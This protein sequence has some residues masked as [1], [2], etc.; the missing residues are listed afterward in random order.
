MCCKLPSKQ[1][2]YHTESAD[3][4]KDKKYTTVVL[5]LLFF[6]VT[7]VIWLNIKKINWYISEKEKINQNKSWVYHYNPKHSGFYGLQSDFLSSPAHTLKGGEKDFY[8][9]VFGL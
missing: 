2:N 3:R 1:K 5:F 8:F 6:I 7:L 9:V 4:N